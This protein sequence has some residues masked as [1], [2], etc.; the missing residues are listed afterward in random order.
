VPTAKAVRSLLAQLNSRAGAAPEVVAVAAIAAVGRIDE[1]V[2]MR[3][4]VAVSL[5]FKLH[6]VAGRHAEALALYERSN[7]ALDDKTRSL[8][9]S[10]E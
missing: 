9:I 4:A 5:L 8:L 3:D 6:F 1:E 10:G 7:G 2:Y